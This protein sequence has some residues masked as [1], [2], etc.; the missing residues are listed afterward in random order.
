[1][2]ACR[3]RSRSQEVIVAAYT[4][5]VNGRRLEVT[6]DPSTPLLWVLR[7]D[8]K[9]TGTKYGCGIA[10]CGACTVLVGGVATRSCAVPISLLGERPVVTIEGIGTG[11]VGRRVQGGWGAT[12][13]LPWGY[14]PSGPNM[15]AGA[16]F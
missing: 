8:L 10:A 11:P 7:E 12:A 14:C 13:C 4:L 15:K 9:M 16:R 3:A 6:T 2:R 1:M 5:T